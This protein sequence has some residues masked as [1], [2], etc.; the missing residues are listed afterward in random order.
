LED[1]S[2]YTSTLTSIR[3]EVDSSSVTDRQADGKISIN[4]AGYE[5]LQKITGVGPV[6]A[7]RIIEY[8]EENGPF[9]KLEDLKDVKG[10]GEAT[11]LKMSGEIS[12]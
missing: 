4:T 6:I 5:E 12:L 1:F 10:I 9:G 3:K 11:F 2:W 8:R 7:G